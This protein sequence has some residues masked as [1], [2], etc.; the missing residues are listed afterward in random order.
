MTLLT[1]RTNKGDH[2]VKKIFSHIYPLTKTRNYTMITYLPEGN[3][4][5]VKFNQFI[6]SADVTGN[7]A[8]NLKCVVLNNYL[9]ISFDT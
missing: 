5:K 4:R 7:I 1:V 8:L 3:L 9:H 2:S 6:T